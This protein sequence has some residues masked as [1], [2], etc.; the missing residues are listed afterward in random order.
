MA[1]LPKDDDDYPYHRIIFYDSNR[2]PKRKT[3]YLKKSS[4]YGKAGYTRSEAKEWKKRREIAF[5]DGKWNPW[6]EQQAVQK[7]QQAVSLGKAIKKYLKRAKRELAATTVEARDEYLSHF[8]SVFGTNTA[9]SN[10]SEEDLEEWVNEHHLKYKSKMKRLE[11]INALYKY[12]DRK[13]WAEKPDITVYAKRSEKKRAKRSSKTWVSPE[14]YDT[15]KKAAKKVIAKSM[16]NNHIKSAKFSYLHTFYEEFD[17]V[18]DFLI[19]TA[20]RRSDFLNLSTAWFIRDCK[21][22]KIGDEQYQPKSQAPEEI[23]PLTPE[24]RRIARHWIERF[25]ENTRPFKKVR[26][27]YFTDFFK[28]VFEK[29][30]PA[31]ADRLSAHKMR[32]S[33]A[34]YLLFEKGYSPQTVQQITRHEDLSTLN[35]YLHWAPSKGL[36]EIENKG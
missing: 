9:L 34:M 6:N 22:M 13:G 15:V 5:K 3:V 27:R 2:S 12:V 21:M 32:D 10:I 4:H 23:I 36:E 28:A 14:E 17:N 29:A 25:G 19:N 24:A 30:L 20:L 35:I 1:S 18:F 11:V 26:K 8:K 33:A 7:E 16:D 31:K